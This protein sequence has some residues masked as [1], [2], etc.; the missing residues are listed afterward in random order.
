MQF[1][2]SWQRKKRCMQ[3]DIQSE[4][5]WSTHNTPPHQCPL[6]HKTMTL[7]ASK[8]LSDFFTC[9]PCGYECERIGTPSSSSVESV[10]NGFPTG[11]SVWIDPAVYRSSIDATPLASQALIGPHHPKKQPN[12]TT[13]VPL[14]ASAQR[15][16]SRH[17]TT[18]PV[19]Q[20]ASTTWEYESST[21][22]AG[23]S[24]S[25]LS[26][27]VSETPTQP[28]INPPSA[29][30][31]TRRLPDIDEIDTTPP[32][33]SSAQT[34]PSGRQTVSLRLDE[35]AIAELSPV[36]SP[37]H[38]E[39][40]IDKIDTLPDLYSGVGR[41]V[42]PSSSGV[43]RL[44]A[45]P[46]FFEAVT[47]PPTAL[48]LPTDGTRAMVSRTHQSDMVEGDTASWTAGRGA[49]S[50]YAQLIANHTSRKRIRRKLTLNPLDR[51]R[52]WL[53]HPGRFEFMLWLLGTILL[54]TVTC[55]FLLLTAFSLNWFTP[56]LPGG[57][58]SSNIVNAS[59]GSSSHSSTDIT[60]TPTSTPGL[61]LTLL[62]KGPIV[63]GQSIQ[64]Q[65]K[66]FTPHGQVA[67]TYDGTHTFL[68]QNDNP[69]VIRADAHGAF[70]VTIWPRD[71]STWNIGRHTII[72]RDL[73]TN[74]IAI[75][76]ITLSAGPFGK[77]VPTTPAPGT[78]PGT[79]PTGGT[80]GGIAPTPVGQTPVP[81]TP[82]V[83][84][85]PSPVPSP[86]PSPT[87]VPP[88]PSPSPS[89]SP[90]SGS[91]PTP[92]STSTGNLSSF[93]NSNSS[94]PSNLGNVLSNGSADSSAGIQQPGFNPLVLLMIACYTLAIA[95]LGVAGVLHKR[96]R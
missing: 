81:V 24:L 74:H 43:S 71:W 72:A 40:P 9:Y 16:A 6:C 95:L 78:T 96:R 27:L 47:A 84:S 88:S 12:P 11:S 79:T 69:L 25:S 92:T 76:N 14:R 1:H 13:P 5:S 32:P 38:P 29:R 8:G 68:D 86:S 51:V 82:T 85:T 57:T 33:P 22:A 48:I 94:D 90:T 89:P 80:G 56:A 36:L 31:E 54:I 2:Y 46:T 65:G 35:A 3:I 4:G 44:P 87:Q 59:T 10:L 62:D 15:S 49:N 18:S 34:R 60:S 23:S 39:T 41:E 53:L 50:S 93:A 73:K 52:W 55:S 64:L 21:Y 19:K 77:T 67:L 83:T 70:I 42:Q 63:L 58:T 28:Q 17:A 91:T 66:G 45:T 26:L 75:Y 61:Q 20:A 30:K 37:L 7:V